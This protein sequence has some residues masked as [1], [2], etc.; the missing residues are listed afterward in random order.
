[1]SGS[2]PAAAQISNLPYRGFAIRTGWKFPHLGDVRTS[3]ECNSA[4]QQIE[5][6]RY[7]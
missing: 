4:I 2:Q 1:V 6:L 5:N 7:D 3:A